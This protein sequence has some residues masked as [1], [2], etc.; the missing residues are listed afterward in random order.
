VD[1]GGQ[2]VQ[3]AAA[4]DLESIFVILHFLWPKS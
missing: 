4:N 2:T 3:V 1:D